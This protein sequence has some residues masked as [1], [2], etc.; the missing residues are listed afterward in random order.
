MVS[1][2]EN[3]FNKSELEN[4]YSEAI[5]QQK[6]L[7][8]IDVHNNTAYFEREFKVS[9]YAEEPIN[10]SVAASTTFFRAD[11]KTPEQQVIYFKKIN[12]AV[13]M[14]AVILLTDGNKWVNNEAKEIAQKVKIFM[15]EM[16]IIMALQFG[17]LRDIISYDIA[18]VIYEQSRGNDATLTVMDGRAIFTHK[19]YGTDNSELKIDSLNISLPD[20]IDYII[21]SSNLGK[22]F[23]DL[24]E[25]TKPNPHAPLDEDKYYMWGLG[26]VR[27]Y[28]SI[29]AVKQ[30][31]YDM[32]HGNTSTKPEHSGGI[33][34]GQP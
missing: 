24:A 13:G 8:I 27:A 23:I 34:N 6:H 30:A 9:G 2:I 10:P 15:P 32:E 25:L 12:E 31:I 26:L 1:T 11:Y 20:N 14:S 16:P 5:E 4:K 28:E 21:S 19:P 17:A 7:G 18:E 22:T 29:P 3:A 33:S